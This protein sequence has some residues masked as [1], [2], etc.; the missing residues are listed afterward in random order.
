MDD[1]ELQTL[2]LERSDGVATI[3][4]NRPERLNAYT[5]Q[6][7]AEIYQSI[8]ALD[9]DDEIRAIIVTGAGRG[10]CAG[11]DLEGGGV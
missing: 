1:G 4:L 2:L 10:F 9:R 6:M 5:V 11:M 8:E 7:G 3:T